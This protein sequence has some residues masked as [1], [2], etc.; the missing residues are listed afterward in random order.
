MTN[1]FL[2]RL[3]S[4][5]GFTAKN[6]SVKRSKKSCMVVNLAN[7]TKLQFLC[8]N[9]ALRAIMRQ[10]PKNRCQNLILFWLGDKARNELFEWHLIARPSVL[11][12]FQGHLEDHFVVAVESM[13]E[14]DRF[15]GDGVGDSFDEK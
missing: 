15:A 9:V 4:K 2:E 8:K 3:P 7:A 13:L 5:I 12:S 6:R 14:I 1:T 10:Y 11:G